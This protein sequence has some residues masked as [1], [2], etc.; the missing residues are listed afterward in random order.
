M[1]TT[2]TP[3][4]DSIRILGKQDDFLDRKIGQRGE[5]YFDYEIGTLRVFNGQV[6]GVTLLKDDLSNISTAALNKNVNF[7]TGTITATQFIGA[8]I[9]AVLGDS[10]PV[11]PVAQTGTLWFNTSTGKLYIY[12]NDGTS[13]QWVQP[14]T[15]S[16]GGGSGGG[17]GSGTVNSGVAGRIAYYP[18]SGTSVDDLSG[19]SWASSTLGITGSINVSAQKNFVRFHW[20]TLNDLNNEANPTTWHGMIAHVHETGRV[21]FAHSGV[22]TPLALQSEISGGVANILA[23]DNVTISNNSG[24]Y[25]INA[26]VGGGGGGISLEEAQDG[27]ATLFSNGSHTGITFNYVD[28]SNALNAVVTDIPLG[29]RT[30]GN[31]VASITT[32]SGITGGTAGSEGAVPTLG[33]DSSVVV[34]V[35]EV[36]TLTN[37]TINGSNNTITGIANASLTNSSITINGTSV[38]LGGTITVSSGGAITT[39]D[40]LTDVVITS[41][42]DGQVLKYNGANWVNA[43]DATGAGG[44]GNSF[45]TIAVA[46]QSPVGADSATDTLTLVAGT[47]IQITTDANTDTVTITNSGSAI[48]TFST[49]AVTGQSN[50]VADSSTDTLT[51]TAGTGI[52]IT[53]DANTDAITITST[54]SAG[55]TTFAALTD[56]A[57]LTADQFYLPA[58]TK[59]TVTASGSSAYLFDQYTGNNPTVYAISG[60]TIAF[61]LG[62]GAL[63]SHPFLIR[64]SGANYSTGLVH[65]TTTGTVTT[66]SSAQGKT[67]GTLYWKIPAGI[68]GTYGY[69]CQSHGTMIGTITI[70][71]ITAI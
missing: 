12:Y 46:G 71:D 15:P 43:A 51:L 20:E 64:F 22:W 7:G 60:T 17:S 1:A 8:G 27:A 19:V 44:S 35:T 3:V 10:P 49:I 36:Q 29:T 54:A 23:G 11:A 45:T 4:F 16:V 26:V 67:S 5:I 53:T 63:S 2:R 18:A 66:G 39:L 32:T 55:A 41:A 62:T 30:T 37:K 25:T 38:S 34:L 69:L 21:Y 33:I 70:K 31:Y 13:L 6:G 40:S 14:M 24:T 42:T 65:V 47:G 50:V 56:N 61:D 28:G 58:I 9:G 59:L 48:N 57:G 52:Q 68:S